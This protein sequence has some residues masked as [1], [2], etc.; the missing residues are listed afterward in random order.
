M[1]GDADSRALGCAGRA[2]TGRKASTRPAPAYAAWASPA[3]VADLPAV[4][5]RLAC[6]GR[7]R[8]VMRWLPPAIANT[9]EPIVES[10]WIA[11]R[12]WCGNVARPQKA[13]TSPT[14]RSG[15]SG[16]QPCPL[17]RCP[18]GSEQ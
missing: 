5:A 1:E 4:Q 8:P 18:L 3:D 6:P 17:L 11:H 16:Y 2:I 9:A 13:P 15:T 14:R 12:G 10:E 7:W